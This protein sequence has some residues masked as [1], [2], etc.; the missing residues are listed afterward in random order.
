MGKKKSA[1]QIRRMEMRAK[2][3]GEEYIRDSTL[4]EKAEDDVKCI[5]KADI[6]QIKVEA[7]KRLS[8]ELNRIEADETMNSKTRRAAKR[9][10]EA[11]A[12]EEVKK[13]INDQVGDNGDTSDVAHQDVT[14]ECLLKLASLSQNSK[15]KS[16]S[17]EKVLDPILEI[18]LSAGK[19]LVHE[20]ETIDTDKNIN[21]KERR[22]QKRKAEAI[23]VQEVMV[24][25][26]TD[27][28]NAING[29]TGEEL[30][31]VVRNFEESRNEQKKEK[32]GKQVDGN[33]KKSTPYIIFVGQLSYSTTKSMIIDHF[34]KHLKED[35][36][37]GS[38]SSGIFD[39]RLLTD[40]KTGKSRGMA[41][42]E[43]ET[44]EILHACFKLH[45]THLDGRR[46]NVERTGGGGA[47]KRKETL[48]RYHEEHQRYVNE[49]VDNIF[50]EYLS[51][52]SL[53][54]NELDDSVVGLCKRHSMANVEQALTEYIQCRGNSLENP[55]AYLTKILS[56]I[57][58]EGNSTFEPKRQRKGGKALKYNG[59]RNRNDRAFQ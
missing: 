15:K 2:A 37:T 38:E 51:N 27:Q 3:R 9:K 55:S 4:D 36:I 42:V 50:K 24:Q 10:A 58:V 57:A 35:D 45:Q 53:Q 1:A 25:V 41:F 7:G 30:V 46:I 5:N 44:P 29:L 22:S 11:V 47:K 43:V 33:G 56:R 32:K 8:E 23:A 26:P 14:P 21:S 16:S 48:K 28:K 18:K 17:K 49:T 52:G 40:K 13:V 12:V 59:G 31:K 39:V 6:N 54:E 34:E 19:K 20:L